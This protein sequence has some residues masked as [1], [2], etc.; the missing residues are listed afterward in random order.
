MRISDW[1]SDVCSSDLITCAETMDRTVLHA[2]RDHT[3][4]Y[5]IFHDEIERE[6]F[7]EEIGVVFQAL[8]IKRVQHGVAGAVG[9]GAG[10]LRSRSRAHILH[11]AAE[12]ALIDL[13]LFSPAER[14]ARMLQFI[15]SSRR[16]TAEI[17]DCVLI[18]QDR[19]RQ[20]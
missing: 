8:L 11:H 10:A 16:F 13:A 7:D 12:G 19:Q 1:S 15:N 17:F 14:N 18:T 20:R 3:P 9:S 5:A 6:I 4:A 2:E